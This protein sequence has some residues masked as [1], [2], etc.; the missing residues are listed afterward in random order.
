MKNPYHDGNVVYFDHGGGYA[1]LQFIKL[2]RIKYT[3]TQ[4]Q[5]KSE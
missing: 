2:N 1:N 3:H 4:I 5:V